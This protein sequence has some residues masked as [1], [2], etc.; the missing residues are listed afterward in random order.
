MKCMHCGIEIPPTWVVALN[1]NICPACGKAIMDDV[2]KDLIKDL[3]EAMKQMPNNPEGLAGWLVSNYRM[4]KIG[5][6][7]PVNFV[8]AQKRPPGSMNPNATESNK[9]NALEG[10]FARA[11]VKLDDVKSGIATS[12]DI[13][14]EGSGGGGGGVQPRPNMVKR[15]GQRNNRTQGRDP[16]DPESFVSTASV[17]PSTEF[18]DEVDSIPDSAFFDGSVDLPGPVVDNVADMVANSGV[19]PILEAQAMKQEMASGGLDSGVGRNGKSTGFRR[20]G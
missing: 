8:T 13:M 7:E 11:G 1:S 18:N 19:S 20:S 5:A 6:Y 3:A 17:E 10:F 12:S 9:I 2:A 15:S 14:N 4:Q 16:F